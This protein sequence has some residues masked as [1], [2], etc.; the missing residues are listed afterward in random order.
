VGLRVADPLTLKSLERMRSELPS[1]VL[2]L[3]HRR[4][5]FQKNSSTDLITTSSSTT[6]QTVVNY[7]DL[8]TT[9]RSD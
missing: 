6:G 1:R 5:P 2:E 9:I 3:F 4:P 7:R 8:F